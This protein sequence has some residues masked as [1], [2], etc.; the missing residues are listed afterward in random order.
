MTGMNGR[1]LFLFT[2][3]FPYGSA[4]KY[5]SDEL[6]FLAARFEKIVLVP[7]EL[8][9][10]AG[11]MQYPLPENAE[12]LLINELPGLKNGKY[13]KNITE[14]I[15]L[16]AYE[17]RHHPVKKYFRRFFRRYMSILFYQQ[18]VAGV[19]AD[20][21]RERGTDFT[22]T[23][24]YTYWLHNSTL[25][26]GLLKKRGL[27]RHFIS[28]AHSID[29]YSEW[30]PGISEKMTPLPFFYFKLKQVDRVFTISA[31]GQEHLEKHFPRFRSKYAI[32][33]LG[34]EDHGLN[35][36]GQG[37]EFVVVTCAHLSP[38][39]RITRM[40]GIL[41]RLDFPVRW[42]HF[43]GSGAS[44]EE[45]RRS[46]EKLPAH[47]HADLKGF[48][49]SGNIIRYYQQNPVHLFVNLSLL[50]GL[51]VSI[52]EASS[53]GIPSMATAVYGTP[54]IVNPSSGHLLPQDFTDEEAA[55]FIRKLAAD[56]PLQQTLRANARSVFEKDFVATVNFERFIAAAFSADNT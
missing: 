23:Y 11:P 31:H 52:M 5:I 40:P 39:K 36:A 15:A 43:G 24:F 38:N 32:A 46:C 21:L 9:G 14:A 48:V 20:Y 25:M 26:L 29:L 16:A 44:L 28:R 42:V 18:A 50:E 53:F 4:E 1:T 7:S 45:L 3:Q 55:A 22:N 19:F 35:H 13:R 49:S 54:E 41:A 6:P 56:K 17:Y 30:W 2:K 12:L 27:I 51:P 33:R 10:A 8:F 37:G 34:V 47:I